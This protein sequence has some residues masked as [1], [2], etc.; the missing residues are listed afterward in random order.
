MIYSFSIP[1][2][3]VPKGRPRFGKGHAYTPAKTREAEERVRA[4]AR[5]AGIRKPAEGLVS[6]TA[7]FYGAER[8][9]VDNLAK[10][11]LDSLNK[12][13][14]RDDRQVRSMQLWKLPAD[15][16]RPGTLVTIETG[17]GWTPTN[18]WEDGWKESPIPEE[19]P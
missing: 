18:M 7:V 12:L 5:N 3:P 6:V 17:V 4:A 9:D 10:L 14:W 11:I 16:C 1:G 19:I 8:S 15:G 2:T 13:A